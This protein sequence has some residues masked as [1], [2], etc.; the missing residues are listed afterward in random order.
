MLVLTHEIAALPRN[1]RPGGKL[2]TAAILEVAPPAEFSYPQPARG[3]FCRRCWIRCT[4]RASS[5]A[6]CFDWHGVLSGQPLPWII[7]GFLTTVWVSVAWI[8]LATLLVVLLLALRLGGG[9]AG[10]D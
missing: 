5:D 2:S 10:A 3:V 8:L 7:S 6:R 9:R 4:R 1:C